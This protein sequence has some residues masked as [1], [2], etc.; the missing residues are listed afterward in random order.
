[1]RGGKKKR[2]KDILKSNGSHFLI[3]ESLKLS[4]CVCGGAC[5]CVIGFAL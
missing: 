5:E 4:V 3:S 1:M 2:D